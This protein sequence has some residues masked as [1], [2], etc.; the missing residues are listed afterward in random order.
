MVCARGGSV[1]NVRPAHAR[2]FVPVFRLFGRPKNG[3]TW[4]IVQ[5]QV[6]TRMGIILSDEEAQELFATFDKEGKGALSLPEVIKE[7]MPP[8][9]TRP[10]WNIVRDEEMTRVEKQKTKAALPYAIWTL[11]TQSCGHSCMDMCPL[12]CI[13]VPLL[14]YQA[15]VPPSLKTQEW[16]LQDFIETLQRK[17]VERTKRPSDQFREGTD[18]AMFRAVLVVADC[19]SY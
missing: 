12:H 14:R 5:R 15:T 9:Y 8:D 18:G 11:R 1:L 7:L 17:I 4:E 16:H 13:L 10:T 2:S 19:D 3:V 6:H